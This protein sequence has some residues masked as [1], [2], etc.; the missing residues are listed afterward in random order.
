M[1]SNAIGQASAYLSGRSLEL[2]VASGDALEVR[3]FSVTE[4]VSALFQVSITAVCKN[5][6]VEFEAVVGQAARF[7]AR[8]THERCWSGLVSHIEQVRVES[9]GVSTY[10][11]TVVPAL[12]LLTQRKNTRMFQYL[13]E[14]DIVIQILREW[15]IDPD[16]RIDPGAYKKRKYRVQYGESDY[17]FIS[18]MLEDAGIAFF[19]EQVD[20]ESKLVLAD[21]P[22]SA[23]PRDPPLPFSDSPTGRVKG[24]E[25][26]TAVRI[27]RRVRP[28]RYT[29]R[30]HDY[31]LPPS[32]PLLASSS[33]GIGIEDKLERYQYTPGAF[34]FGGDKGES[35]PSADDRGKARTDEGE[36]AT[37]AR[38]RLEAKQG[39][40]TSCSFETN[41][42][43]LAPGVVMRISGHP[44]PDLGDGRKLLIVESSFHGSP[45]GDWSH[46][47]TARGTE[48]PYRP[49]LVTP[50]PKVLGVESATVVGPAGE[51]IHTDEFGR[52]RVHFHW[53]RESSMNEKSSC[54]IHVSHAWGGSGFGGV[55]LPRIGQEV[56]VG[57][58]GGDPDR[59][60]VVG[61]VYTNLQKVPY[62]LPAA[63][64][65]SGWRS[66]SSPGGGGY[67]EIMFEDSKGSELLNMQAEKDLTKLVKND[68]TRTIGHDRTTLVKNDETRTIGHDRTTLVQ[69]DED[70]TIG[71]NRSKVVQMNEREVVGESRTRA[72]G[73]NE[74]VQIG[75][76]QSLAVGAAQATT[77]GAAQS[78]QVGASRS[79]AVADSQSTTIGAA[80]SRS[81]GAAQSIEVGES[82]SLSVGG[83]ESTTVS[84]A[85][86]ETVG[87]AKALTV[88]GAYQITVG[89]AMNTTVALVQAEEVGLF[90]TVMVGAKIEITCGM[91]KLT[92]DAAGKIT[93]SGTDLDINMKGPVKINGT[94]IVVKASG[95]AELEGASVKITGNPVDIN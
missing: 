83:S 84:K 6:G 42:H 28:G 58:L 56:L 40:A 50:K 33:G 30:D 88:G 41:A 81:V 12:W 78:L 57:F 47:H 10:Q 65:K 43:D 15:G 80:E 25:R 35:N 90:K 82:R 3:R 93:L 94:D 29:M 61:R 64:T 87:L 76:N 32:Y 16:L 85:S 48:I 46:E 72:V 21:A 68:E 7:T 5:A 91:S 4:Q 55:N 52:V 31:R 26:V 2:E 60:V 17:L 74:S 20:G 66:A 34:L 73:V 44:R 71:N 37:V 14:P 49:A 18:R 69:N 8:G 54:W 86:T 19:F 62:G 51:E 23:E 45:G 89:G 67:N 38:K 53:D 22:H 24:Q 59:P 75:E 11:L 77:V 39:A 92:M 79:V 13:S 70:V 1:T 36:A 9:E 27:G 63:K 95:K